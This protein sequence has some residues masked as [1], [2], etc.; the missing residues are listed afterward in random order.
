MLQ[1]T[2]ELRNALSPQSGYTL[3][4]GDSREEVVAAVTPVYL[5]LMPE[6]MRISGGPHGGT[7][8]SEL[9]P[10]TP[11]SIA[12]YDHSTPEPVVVF[13]LGVVKE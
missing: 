7:P 12:V 5:A 6:L 10:V 9:I 3:A 1:Y 13:R 2:A 8:S 4:E 11:F